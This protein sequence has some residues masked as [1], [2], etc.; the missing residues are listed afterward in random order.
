[1]RYSLQELRARKKETQ[2]QAA[3]ALGVSVP[4]YASWENDLA[5]ASFRNVM[6]V[7][8][9][10]GVPLNELLLYP[11]APQKLKE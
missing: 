8:Q 4:T 3:A 9:H 10:F 6:K 5:G 11:E 7:S 1:M 2:A